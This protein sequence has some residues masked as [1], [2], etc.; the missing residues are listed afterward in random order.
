[1]ANREGEEE[2]QT[3]RGNEIIGRDIQTEIERDTNTDRL[4]Q[5]ETQR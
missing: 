5:R 3:G 2:R 1:M 4:K